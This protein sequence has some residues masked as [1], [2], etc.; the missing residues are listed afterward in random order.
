MPLPILHS[1]D[2]SPET[3]VRLFHKTETHWTQHLAEETQLD[4]GS[5]FVNA[6]FP[7]IKDANRVLSASLPDGVSPGDAIQSVNEHYAKNGTICLM[8]VMNP[9]ADLAA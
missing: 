6:A 4:I 2:A 9:S 8:W 3:L 7:K 5:A 1:N